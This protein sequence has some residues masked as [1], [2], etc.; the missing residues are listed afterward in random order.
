MSSSDESSEEEIEEEEKI[1]TF[2]EKEEKK[3][4]FGPFETEHLLKTFSKVYY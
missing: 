3:D 4:M 1:E 2:E